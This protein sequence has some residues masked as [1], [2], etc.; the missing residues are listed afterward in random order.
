MGEIIHRKVKSLETILLENLGSLAVPLYYIRNAGKTIAGRDAYPQY[1][2]GFMAVTG[3]HYE[4]IFL[5]PVRE[6]EKVQ[7]Y[8][9]MYKNPL[10][11]D[12]LVAGYVYKSEEEFNRLNI[13]YKV[14]QMIPIGDPVE[15]EDE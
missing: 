2:E 3:E 5:E 13:G 6:K 14:L 7:Y 9:V 10:S 12:I 8:Q 4:E 15:V 1:P 11:G